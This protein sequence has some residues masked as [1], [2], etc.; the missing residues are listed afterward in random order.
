MKSTYNPGTTRM[1]KKS[2]LCGLYLLSLASCEHRI[3]QSQELMHDDGRAKPKVAILN[4]VDHSNSSLPW[5]LSQELTD[6]ITD[7]LKN[8]GSMFIVGQDELTWVKE[9]DFEKVNPFKDADFI[10]TC[11]PNA[12]FVVCIEM[13]N[14]LLLPS[15]GRQN[16]SHPNAQTHDLNIKARVKVFDIRKEVP[17]LILSEIVEESQ[18][19]PWQ[20]S[21]ID[22][23]KNH[24]KTTQ[25][26]ITPIGLCHKRLI[27]AI[28]NHL[29]DY[30]LLAKSI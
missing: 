5:D 10:K 11:K 1:L 15:K 23:R 9:P 29:Q 12:E 20:L 22:Y 28:A 7:K 30:V 19:V 6:E 27:N 3:D 4:I 18:T 13:I 24:F 17:K 2:L 21:T 8:Q 16:M 26:K 25:Y 14:H